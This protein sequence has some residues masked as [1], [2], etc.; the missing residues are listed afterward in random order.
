[1]AIRWTTGSCRQQDR[2]VCRLTRWHPPGGLLAAGGEGLEAQADVGRQ[3]P[4][5]H[6]LLGMAMLLQGGA[7]AGQLLQELLAHLAIGA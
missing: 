6:H 1:M 7:L 3:G 2:S 5:G 4:K